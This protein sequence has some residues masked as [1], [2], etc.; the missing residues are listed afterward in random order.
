MFHTLLYK[1]R[2]VHHFSTPAVISKLSLAHNASSPSSIGHSIHPC[3]TSFTPS[4]ISPTWAS[5]L[6]YSNKSPSDNT[7]LK[8][9]NFLPYNSLA[10]SYSIQS[11][12][13]SPK[14]TCSKS[15]F[16][17]NPVSPIAIISLAYNNAPDLERLMCPLSIPVSPNP[18]PMHA[19]S[20]HAPHP[21]F[22]LPILPLH[23]LPTY[24]PGWP[25][26]SELPHI[27]TT[28]S[29]SNSN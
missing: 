5:F 18:F 19:I 27:T 13:Y 25:I 28:P 26:Q 15:R 10:P 2:A 14:Y 9:S 17:E 29:M 4:A 12:P 22:P 16:Q 3:D 7:N 20:Y 8:S 1:R 21:S 11:Q 23:H 24:Q 6:T